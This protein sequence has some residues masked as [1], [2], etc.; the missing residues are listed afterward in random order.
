MFQPLPSLITILFSTQQSAWSF[1][2]ISLKALLKTLHWLSITLRVKVKVLTMAYKVLHSLSHSLISLTPSPKT[3]SLG[4]SSHT[5]LLPV[6][7]MHQA[8]SPPQDICTYRSF[9]SKVPPLSG[10][11][12][13]T[14]FS[15]KPS[16]TAP[17]QLQ[18][19]PPHPGTPSS[20]PFSSLLCLSPSYV[21]LVYSPVSLLRK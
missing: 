18:P 5:G 17:L 7:P 16:L 6:S 13:N 12:T 4:H 10:L 8:R 21:I 1:F 9:W 11:Y 3:H 15:M 14:P 19:S 2:K 20:P